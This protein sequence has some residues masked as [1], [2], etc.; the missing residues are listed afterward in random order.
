MI[1]PIDPFKDWDAAYILGALSQEECLEY[2]KHVTACP[3]C[4]TALGEISHLPQILARIDAEVALSLSDGSSLSGAETRWD[5]A[6]FIKRLALRAEAVRKKDRVRVKIGL[7][8]AVIISLT[9][10]VTTGIVLHSPNS[11]EGSATSS[12]GNSLRVTNLHPEVMTALFRATSKTWGTQI[13]WSCTYAVGVSTGYS[14]TSYDLLITDTAGKRSLI[15]T[16]SAAGSKATGLVATTELQIS[17]IKSVEIVL[18]GS[19]DPLVV[20]TII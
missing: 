16:W 2:E 18:S 11:P 12:T 20:G 19:Q 7:V 3:S 14:T 10:G 6:E 13:D 9:V 5:D 1:E 4:S 8:A 15:S 17:Q